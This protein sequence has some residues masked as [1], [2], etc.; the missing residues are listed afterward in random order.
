VTEP[1]FSDIEPACGLIREEIAAALPSDRSGRT[2]QRLLLH[3][4]AS[5]RPRGGSGGLVVVLLRVSLWLCGGSSWWRAIDLHTEAVRAR[6]LVCAG[7]LC[8]DLC[9]PR[10]SL[11][12]ARQI[13]SPTTTSPPEPSL[14]LFKPRSCRNRSRM[15]LPLLSEELAE[16]IPSSSPRRLPSGGR[17]ARKPLKAPNSCTTPAA[18][19]RGVI[20]RVLPPTQGQGGTWPP[21][22]IVLR[23]RRNE[24]AAFEAISCCWV[25]RVC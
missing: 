10:S 12:N 14:G 15:V 11:H 3:E 4:R 19:S 7:A 20:H 8:G 22:A 13:P 16:I 21:P 25:V 2:I 24:P 1:D 18:G 5:K 17:G 23:A 6:G 9:L